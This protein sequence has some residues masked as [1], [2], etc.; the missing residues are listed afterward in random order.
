MEVTGYTPTPV[1]GVDLK[2]ILNEQDLALRQAAMQRAGAQN[3]RPPLPR[4]SH[5]RNKITGLV[6]PWN[7]ILA[8]QRDIMECCDADGNTDPTAWMD[9]VNP[10]EYTDAERD[11]LMAQARSSVLQHAKSVTDTYRQDTPVASMQPK[12]S[13]MPFGAQSLDAYYEGMEKDMAPLLAQ[14]SD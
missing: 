4:S 2:G 5:L 13:D 3:T 11:E 7:D 10:E 9:T 8:E 14:L 6:L 1:A 12:S